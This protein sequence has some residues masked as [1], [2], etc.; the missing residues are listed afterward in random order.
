LIEN[1]SQSWARTSICGGASYGVK[2]FL[3]LRKSCA[4]HQQ[5][6]I[7]DQAL[8]PTATLNKFKSGPN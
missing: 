4:F 7:D 1:T 6:F 2:S 3:R 5:L 8:A